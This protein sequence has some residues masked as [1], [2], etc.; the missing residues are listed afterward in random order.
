[1]ALLRKKVDALPMRTRSDD[2]VKGLDG[3]LKTIQAMV[4]F[5]AGQTPTQA[6]VKALH[7]AASETIA[8]ITSNK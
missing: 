8:A 7:D 2:L 5:P 6:D 4:S 3:R 1:V